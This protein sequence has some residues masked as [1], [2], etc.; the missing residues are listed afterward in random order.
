MNGDYSISDNLKLYGFA[1]YATSDKSARQNFRLPVAIWQ[2]NPALLQVYPD[3]FTPTID[4]E[5]TDYS[6]V[7]GL[8]AIDRRMGLMDRCVGLQPRLLRHLHAQHGQSTR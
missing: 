5:E 4:T 3:G 7:G 6:V 1:T 2:R 8:K